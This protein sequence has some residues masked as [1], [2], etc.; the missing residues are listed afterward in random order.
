[1]CPFVRAAELIRERPLTDIQR[2]NRR[3]LDA[4][5]QCWLALRDFAAAHRGERERIRAR[6]EFIC[7]SF[8][9]VRN[10]SILK[11]LECGEGDSFLGIEGCAEALDPDMDVLRVATEAAMQVAPAARRPCLVQSDE[12]WVLTGAVEGAL[13]IPS[14]A[15]LL[16]LEVVPCPP[17]VLPGMERRF[18]F[19]YVRLWHFR[20]TNAAG[21]SVSLT[22]NCRPAREALTSGAAVPW[23][24]QPP[25]WQVAFQRGILC[26]AGDALNPQENV[27]DFEWWNREIEVEIGGIP[28][29]GQVKFS[30]P[31]ASGTLTLAVPDGS[32]ALWGRIHGLELVDFDAPDGI[33][34]VPPFC[35]PLNAR[36]FLTNWVVQED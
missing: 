22:V 24:R 5:D 29:S 10:V 15:A 31:R 13:I 1:V 30:P 21:K 11:I 14:G 33:T 35:F 27:S 8:C 28:Y 34:I 36:D 32:T 19:E 3:S 20:V 7:Q 25:E 9:G 17:E 18:C 26:T 4:Q 12:E 16:H 6:E 23:D 2:R